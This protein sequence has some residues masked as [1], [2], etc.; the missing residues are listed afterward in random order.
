MDFPRP[1]LKNIIDTNMHVSFT[2]V[3]TVHQTIHTYIGTQHNVR[4]GQTI[5]EG[6]QTNIQ[7]SNTGS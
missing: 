4:G 2:G 7:Q 1:A 5:V 6:D 3:P